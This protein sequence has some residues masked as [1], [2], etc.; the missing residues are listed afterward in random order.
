MISDTTWAYLAG[1]IDGEGTV[2]ITSKLRHYGYRYYQ[3]RI[4]VTNTK[5]ALLDYC[6]DNFGGFIYISAKG[7]SKR[8]V[9]YRWSL[10]GDRAVTVLKA[11]LP[12]LVIKKN[13]ADIVIKFRESGLTNDKTEAD[14]ALIHGFLDPLK[15]LNQRGVI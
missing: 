3:P 2:K 4:C 13:Q 7:T 10:S 9:A 12:Y 14:K 5:M 8:N 11:L 6:K 15:N 1:L